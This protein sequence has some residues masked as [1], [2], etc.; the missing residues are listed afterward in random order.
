M[1]YDRNLLLC[2][3]DE[4]LSR[5]PRI[6]LSEISDNLGVERHTIEKAILTLRG[7]SFREYEQEV[8]LLVARE[9]LREPYPI[10]FKGCTG[11]CPSRSGAAG[12]WPEPIRFNGIRQIPRDLFGLGSARGG[13]LGALP[14]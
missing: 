13:G 7:V 6:L 14:P 10:Q 5:N 11:G 1:A 9:R 4:L 2:A 3:V 8:L 12:S